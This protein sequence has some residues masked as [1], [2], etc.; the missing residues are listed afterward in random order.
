MD[1]A[2]ALLDDV[3]LAGTVPELAAALARLTAAARQV[4]LALNPGKC[5]LSTC[6]DDGLVDPRLFPAGIVINRSGTFTMLGAPMGNAQFC[7]EHTMAKRVEASKPL[8]KALGDL[9][10][11]QTGLLLVRE[12]AAYCRVVYSSRVVPPPLHAGALN[13]FDDEVRGCLEHLCT[14]PLP[15]EAWLQA[16]LS[17]SQGGLGL[18]LAHRHSPA[19][20]L[21]SAAAT[22][23]LC[24]QLDAHYT[25][26]IRETVTAYNAEVLPADRVS[27]PVP[28][29]TRQQQLS[30]ALDRNTLAQLSAPAPGR[31][32]YRAHLQLLQQ[33][34]AGAWLHAPPAEALGLHVALSLFKVMVRLRLRMQVGKGDAACPLC[35]A[36][37]LAEVTVSNGTT[38]C[39]LS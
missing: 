31:E 19:A 21:S 23:E 29:P 24:Q 32:A 28:T 14:G 18:R 39:V 16:T 13:A 22:Q 34:G 27:S 17:T 36:L 1:L 25:A 9:D 12:C 37:A 2:Y 6:S 26:A 7:T 5:A 20:Y 38:A 33:P 11:P 8:L 10:D 4:G 3:C 30:Q 15:A 35:D